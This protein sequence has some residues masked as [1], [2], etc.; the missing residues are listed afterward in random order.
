MTRG[1]AR[2]TRAFDDPAGTY[3]VLGE[4]SGSVR[5]LQQVM[6]QFSRTH[7]YHR[8][9]VLIDDLKPAESVTLV[10]ADELHRTADVLN[11]A[12]DRAMRTHEASG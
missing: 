3:R 8:D 9:R 5:L 4:V 10:A 6:G 12:A 1:L 2:A 11:E 7:A